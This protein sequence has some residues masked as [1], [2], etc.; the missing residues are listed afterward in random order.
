MEEKTPKFKRRM[1]LKKKR[2]KRMLLKTILY[3]NSI[4]E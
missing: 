4:R 3:S 2:K 1:L